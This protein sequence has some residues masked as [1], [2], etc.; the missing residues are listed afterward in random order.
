MVRGTVNGN[1]MDIGT[2]TG[3]SLGT[4]RCMVWYS[5]VCY[6][7]LKNALRCWPMYF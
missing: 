6:D 5:T 1:G 3:T 4:G 2:V 7:T